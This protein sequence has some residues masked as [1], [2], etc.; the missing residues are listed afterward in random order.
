MD[1]RRRKNSK[2]FSNIEKRNADKKNISKL[3]KNGTEI[4]KTDE[5][6]SETKDFFIKIYI[7]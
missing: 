7:S 6:L 1:R 4:N 3:I 2:Y 5:I